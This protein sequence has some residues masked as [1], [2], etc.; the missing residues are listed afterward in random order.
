MGAAFEVS[1]Q[2]QRPVVTGH[3]LTDEHGMTE[4][5]LLTKYSDWSYECEYRLLAR[6]GE[7][8]LH[9]LASL[10]KTTGDFLQLPEGALT[11]IILGCCS[12]AKC[13]KEV[14][15]TCRPLLKIY[16]AIPDG[17]HY[18]LTIEPDVF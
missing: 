1:Y 16:Q 14:V 4:K 10:P 6:T 8:D 9:S 15:R 13:I 12:D 2:E 18:R 17:D 5:I 3:Q 7:F 11:G